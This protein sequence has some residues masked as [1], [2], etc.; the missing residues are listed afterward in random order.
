MLD[1][2]SVN[3]ALDTVAVEVVAVDVVAVLVKVDLVWVELVETDVVD[4]ASSLLDAKLKYWWNI[5]Y[6]EFELI[7]VCTSPFL[8]E[9][10]KRRLLL[11]LFAG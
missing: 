11:A 4:V 10:R 9:C 3:V 5:E 6:I 1:I 2:V 7:A 8:N